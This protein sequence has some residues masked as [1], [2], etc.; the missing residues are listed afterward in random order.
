MALRLQW[1]TTRL[2]LPFASNA[3][4][5]QQLNNLNQIEKLSELMTP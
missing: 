5:M 2:V 1:L 4:G 3:D